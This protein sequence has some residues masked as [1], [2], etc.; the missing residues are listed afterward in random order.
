MTSFLVIKSSVCG[1]NVTLDL[2][3]KYVSIILQPC[4]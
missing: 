4:I 3:H 2:R 1:E